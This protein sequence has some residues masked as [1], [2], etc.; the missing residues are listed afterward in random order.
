MLS[1]LS[2]SVFGLYTF[3][4]V[5]KTGEQSKMNNKKVL[6]LK[7]SH[8][9]KKYTSCF[10]WNIEEKLQEYPQIERKGRWEIVCALFLLTRLDL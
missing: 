10:S 5:E 4:G 2:Y 7:N 1:R 6:M 8:L 3:K 9:R